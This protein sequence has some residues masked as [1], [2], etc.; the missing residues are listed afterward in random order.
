MKEETIMAR[1]AVATD[2]NSGIT[3]EQGKDLG[4]CPSDALFYQRKI[5]L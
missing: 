4:F 3:Q 1:T 2:S 5:T